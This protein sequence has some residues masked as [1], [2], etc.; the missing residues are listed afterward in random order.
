MTLSRF[1]S[2]RVNRFRPSADPLFESVAKVFKERALGLILSGYLCDGAKG[3]V[4]I[5]ENGGRILV[6]DRITSTAFEMPYSAICAGGVDFV[7]P[8]SKIPQALVTLVMAAGAASLLQVWPFLERD[9]ILLGPNGPRFSK[10]ESWSTESN[11]QSAGEIER[12]KPDGL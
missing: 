8:L 12:L 1:S 5:K 11:F 9:S 10:S 4:R 2:E 3:A 7:L 6:Q